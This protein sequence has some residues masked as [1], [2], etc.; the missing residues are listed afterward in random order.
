MTTFNDLGLD[1]R[2][3]K[4]L[5]TEGYTNPTP[6]QAAAIPS[7]LDGKDILGLAQTGTGKTAAFALPILQRL[8]ANRHP[9]P[10]KGVR[11]LILSPTRELATQIAES[12]R[13]YGRHM[14]FSVTVVFGGVGHKPQ[15][16]QLSRGVDILVATP[17]RLIDHMTER[18]VTLEGT[19]ILVLDEADQMMDLG[20]IRPI[21]QIIAKL[22]HRRQSLFFSA[23]MPHEIGALAAE[24]L[25]DP[26]KVAVTPVAKTADRVT[27]K[28]IH[29][30]QTKKRALLAE[31]F[32]DADLARTIVFTRTK[33]GADRVARYLESAG[34]AC[35]AIHGNK[36]QP[37]RIAAMADFKASRIRALIATD[38]AARGIDID[39]VSH[40]INY[41]MPNVPESYVHR[42][43]RTAR[44]GAEGIAISLVD[45]EERPYLRDIERLTRQTIPSESR[46]G[47][48]RLAAMIAAAPPEKREAPEHQDRRERSGRPERHA[49]STRSDRGR[50]HTSHRDD[51]EA[52]RRAEKRTDGPRTHEGRRERPANERADG[53]ANERRQDHGRRDHDGHRHEGR[54]FEGRGAE[55]RGHGGGQGAHGAPGVQGERGGRNHG[56]P[57]ADRLD[58]RQ[59]EGPRSENHRDRHRSA[60]PHDRRDERRNHAPR[61]DTRDGSSAPKR[62]DEA[63]AASQG[64][65]H[66]RFLRDGLRPDRHHAPSR[67]PRPDDRLKSRHGQQGQNG[68]LGKAQGG[69][70][71]RDWIDQPARKR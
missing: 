50:R 1:P 43:G 30:E 66:V 61:A 28:V 46:V 49:H 51:G 47:C 4:A 29:V 26:V 56:R 42:I 32:A 37:Q 9:A 31:L 35:A 45:A 25:K 5:D 62:R 71:S 6:I 27:Q 13:T 20:F 23:T 34:V 2:L 11:A 40:V 18:N 67:G 7:I 69:H 21:R 54:S 55:R 64:L 52:P 57:S 63:D 65:E 15:R 33:R 53:P 36:S 70:G 12:F 10:H 16:D 17:G 60:R 59:P 14:G 44:A 48:E 8:D 39:A 58:N 3:L 38:I 19:E 41:E 68:K 22:S 24:L